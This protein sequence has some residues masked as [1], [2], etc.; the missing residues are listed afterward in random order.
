MTEGK[1]IITNSWN[2]GINPNATIGELASAFLEAA[3][4]E[5]DAG[6]AEPSAKTRA[7]AIQLENARLNQ[8]YLPT[9][10]QSPKWPLYKRPK[11]Q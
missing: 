6:L 5:F 2:P 9:I 3:V 8:E 7:L 4:R 11:R 10:S 1:D